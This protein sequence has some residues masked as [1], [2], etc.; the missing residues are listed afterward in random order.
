MTDSP[1]CI[2]CG[3]TPAELEEYVEAASAENYGRA[4]SPDLYVRREEGTY[5]PETN[6]FACTPCYCDMG[7]PTTPRGWKAP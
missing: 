2:G 5:N 6:H 1:R 7:M 4:I 3:K